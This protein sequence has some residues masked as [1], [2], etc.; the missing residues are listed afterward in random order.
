MSSTGPMHWHSYAKYAIT[1]LC[2]EKWRMWS[3]QAMNPMSCYIVFR[4]KLNYWIVSCIS[5][6]PPIIRYAY[7]TC[8]PYSLTCLVFRSWSFSKWRRSWLSLK[9]T[10]FID[11]FLTCDWMAT[12]K[13]M[14]VPN[15]FKHSM[16]LIPTTLFSFWVHVLVVW[17]SICNR[18]IQWSYLIR[19]GN[20][21]RHI[22]RRMMMMTYMAS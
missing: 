15:D 12:Q 7:K 21:K 14:I 1:L 20:N 9:T 5:S 16:H 18:Q 8:P 4:A 3:I 17:V 11:S 10:C 19:I 13:V 22:G 6:G 2:F